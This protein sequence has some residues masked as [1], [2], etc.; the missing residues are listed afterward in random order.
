M[1]SVF[2][3]EAVP[4]IRSPQTQGR[5][6]DDI[7][8]IERSVITEDDR[9][10]RSQRRVAAITSA[11]KGGSRRS[12]TTS[13]QEPPLLLPVVTPGDALVSDIAQRMLASS[14][15]CLKYQRYHS[16]RDTGGAVETVFEPCADGN[17]DLTIATPGD[18]RLGLGL[19]SLNLGNQSL[20]L[21]ESPLSTLLAVQAASCDVSHNNALSV[22]DREALIMEFM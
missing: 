1:D 14:N 2:S 19:A 8:V 15:F 12:G 10:H 21:E 22:E 16:D 6:A 3:I 4:L 17:A 11:L 9:S 18:V 13:A 7:V 20:K 5:D